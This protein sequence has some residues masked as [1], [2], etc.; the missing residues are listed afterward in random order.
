M[1]GGQDEPKLSCKGNSQ[2][3]GDCFVLR[4]RL[5][6]V[7]GA[8]SLRMWRVGTKRLLGVEGRY[9]DGDHNHN[10]EA[11]LPE[12]VLQVF[13]PFEN[14]VYADF[15][16]C[17]F[18]K[19]KPGEMQVVCVHSASNLVV[20][21]LGHVTTRHVEPPVEPGCKASPDLVG[22]CFPNRGR[23]EW[24]NGTP[25]ARMWRVGTNRILGVRDGFVPEWIADK[26]TWDTYLFADF[27]VCP[28]TAEKPGQMQVVCIESATN[29]SV[30]ERK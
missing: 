25:G 26:M 20:K 15:E 1:A 18:T 5:S 10:P 28:L 17:P 27:V 24:S 19:E 30:R 21:E 2:L 22:D 12:N 13:S 11:V 9:D 16:V 23:L 8:L 6:A 14:E 4:G 7:N 3:V 29:L